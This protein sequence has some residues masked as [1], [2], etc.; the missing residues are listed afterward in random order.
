MKEF[1][2]NNDL[3]SLSMLSKCCASHFSP[4]TDIYCK[5]IFIPFHRIFPVFCIFTPWHMAIKLSRAKRQKSRHP[6]VWDS[7]TAGI[8]AWYL[9]DSTQPNS[10]AHISPVRHTIQLSYYKVCSVTWAV[11]HIAIVRKTSKAANF[12]LTS[13]ECEHSED[14]PLF[15]WQYS[16]STLLS[17]RIRSSNFFGGIDILET[18]KR[19]DKF[20]LNNTNW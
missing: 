19:V 10:P 1:S 14:D 15:I 3:S 18:D 17:Q 5:Q 13:K 20:L 16:P 6:Y 4:K 9:P 12:K 11:K 7:I 2:F 8:P